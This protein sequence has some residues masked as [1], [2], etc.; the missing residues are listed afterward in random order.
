MNKRKGEEEDKKR[1]NKERKMQRYFNEEKGCAA[2]EI[3]PFR[4]RPEAPQ[5]GGC[6]KTR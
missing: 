5:R 4:V 1:K 2:H 6:L 3:S